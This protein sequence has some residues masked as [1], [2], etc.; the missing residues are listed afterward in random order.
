MTRLTPFIYLFIH[1]F[2]YRYYFCGRLKL[3]KSESSFVLFYIVL[4][5]RTCKNNN[6]RM[7]TYE[8]RHKKGEKLYSIFVT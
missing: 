5:F 1:L 2:I 7:K 4:Y 3:L 6:I 8:G